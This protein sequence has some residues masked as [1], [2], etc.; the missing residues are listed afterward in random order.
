MYLL[1]TNACIDFLEA[2][3]LALAKRIEANFDALAIS[4]IT[5]AELLVGPKT[6][7]D[8]EGD[9]QKLDIFIASVQVVDFDLAAAR[10][11]GDVIRKIGVE[12]NSFDRLIGV[13]ALVLGFTLVTRNGKHFADVPGLRVENWMA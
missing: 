5:A 7:E 6:S 10:A 12:R 11:Y 4:T 2:R 8:P 13:Q 1:D 9:A 3:S